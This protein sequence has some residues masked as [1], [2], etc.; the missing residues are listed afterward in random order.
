MKTARPRRRGRWVLWPVRAAWFMAT[1]FSRR[2]GIL[3]TLV[4]G[5]VLSLVGYLLASTII[6]AVVGLPLMALG[7]LLLARGLW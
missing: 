7:L 3:A 6:G 1:V 5:G 4:A 2:A